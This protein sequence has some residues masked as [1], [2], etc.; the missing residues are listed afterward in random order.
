MYVMYERGTEEVLLVAH[1]PSLGRSALRCLPSA[2]WSSGA[3]LGVV[4]LLLAVRRKRVP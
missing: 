1:K 4:D 3:R 2:V